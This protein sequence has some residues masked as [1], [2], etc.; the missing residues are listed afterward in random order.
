MKDMENQ[1]KTILALL[2]KE[3]TLI[4]S[5][6]DIK[7]IKFCMSEFIDYLKLADGMATLYDE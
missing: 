1:H 2:D 4:Y 6:N 3:W 7:S 5:E